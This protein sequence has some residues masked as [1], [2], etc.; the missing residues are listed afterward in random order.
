MDQMEGLRAGSLMDTEYHFESG[1]SKVEEGYRYG[2]IIND[3]LVRHFRFED[4]LKMNSQAYC[5]FRED[6]VFKQW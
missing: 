5:Q 1:A 3:E 2:L 6:T 4:G